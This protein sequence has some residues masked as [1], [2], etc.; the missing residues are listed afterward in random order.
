VSVEGAQVIPELLGVIPFIA[1]AEQTM[2]GEIV[3]RFVQWGAARFQLRESG[4]NIIVLHLVIVR[5]QVLNVDSYLL[6]P[7]FGMQK[8]KGNES[9][10]TKRSR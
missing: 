3:E 5:N 2:V 4:E 8:F 1:W 10:A 7:V 9:H 6:P